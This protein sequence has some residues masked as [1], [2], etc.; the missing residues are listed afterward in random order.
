MK[1]LQHEVAW[2]SMHRILEA[3]PPAIWEHETPANVGWDIY[4]Q[5]K[6]A[7]E[8]FAAE[9]GKHEHRMRP[10]AN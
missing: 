1:R 3:L 7:L 9:L 8:A 10:S 6:I 2:E 5:I 4:Q